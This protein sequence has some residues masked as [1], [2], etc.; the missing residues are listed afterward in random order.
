M[1]KYQQ[2]LN[3]IKA[4]WRI[5]KRQKSIKI[6][7]W[8]KAFSNAKRRGNVVI[9]DFYD[10]GH[11]GYKLTKKELEDIRKIKITSII[12]IIIKGLKRILKKEKIENE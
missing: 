11:V 6:D 9:G 1:N 7:R 4:E 12:K 3:I 5:R 2:F 8:K 10:T